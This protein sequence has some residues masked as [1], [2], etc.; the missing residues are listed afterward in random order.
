MFFPPT[1]TGVCTSLHINTRRGDNSRFL[2]LSSPPSPSP[3]QNTRTLFLCSWLSNF[4]SAWIQTPRRLFFVPQRLTGIREI[5]S[6]CSSLHPAGF[7]PVLV[8]L[9]KSVLSVL[10]RACVSVS[11]VRVH[12]QIASL[13]ECLLMACQYTTIPGTCEVPLSRGFTQSVNSNPLR[14]CRM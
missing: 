1:C 6:L 7:L 3:L 12:S 9:F 4:S 5:L 13:L 11:P 10:K 8:P 14:N 2:V